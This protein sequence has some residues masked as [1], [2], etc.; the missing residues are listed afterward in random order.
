MVSENVPKKIV[1]SSQKKKQVV[2]VTDGAGLRNQSHQR[3]VGTGARFHWT[4]S[5]ISVGTSRRHPNRN[6]AS[7]PLLGRLG[8]AIGGVGGDAVGHEDKNF[9]RVGAPGAFGGV[10]QHLLCHGQA[11]AGSGTTSFNAI[12][13]RLLDRLVVVGE[14]NGDGTVVAV[15]DDAN[16]ETFLPVKIAAR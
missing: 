10:V 2:L 1:P 4:A 3:L 16:F 15:D 12:D 5:C 8:R 6:Q 13:R 7:S 9:G 14:G 11:L